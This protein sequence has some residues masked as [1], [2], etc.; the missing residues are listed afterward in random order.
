MKLPNQSLPVNRREIIDPELVL[1]SFKDSKGK[2]Q[3]EYRCVRGSNSNPNESMKFSEPIDCG[4]GI[5]S[6]L[7]R[8]MCFAACGIF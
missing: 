6:G 7:A 2:W 3:Q 5:F 1:V 4:C 8:E